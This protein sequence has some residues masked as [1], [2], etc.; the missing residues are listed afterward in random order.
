LT[1]RAVEDAEFN[2]DGPEIW[3]DL[4]LAAETQKGQFN[5]IYC[6]PRTPEFALSDC[7]DVTENCFRVR[8]LPEPGESERWMEFR[9]RPE[10]RAIVVTA[11]PT[12]HASVPGGS[13]S[14]FFGMDSDGNLGSELP[15]P[16]S[17]PDAVRFISMDEAS[18]LLLQ[19]FLFADG[20][21]DPIHPPEC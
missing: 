6:H 14:A 13:V 15:D 11:H 1:R 16:D 10:A 12:S 20:P 9:F 7:R 18:A 17:A 2:R 8:S 19:P 4:S 21:R 5:E 3:R